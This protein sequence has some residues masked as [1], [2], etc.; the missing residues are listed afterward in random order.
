MR[1][2]RISPPNT[3]CTGLLLGA[4][5][6][7]DLLSSGSARQELQATPLTYPKAHLLFAHRSMLSNLEGVAVGH[8]RRKNKHAHTRHL[9]IV[10]LD[11]KCIGSCNHQQANIAQKVS[12]FDTSRLLTGVFQAWLCRTRI[13]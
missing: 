2:L 10:H 5:T 3:P 9:Q 1:T 7:P 12:L 11:S 13:Y 6:P 4:K 8:M